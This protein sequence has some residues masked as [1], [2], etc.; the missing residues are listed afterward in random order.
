MLMRI[1]YSSLRLYS[2]IIQN[3]YNGTICTCTIR[4][5]SRNVV[6]KHTSTILHTVKTVKLYYS[7][8]QV[9]QDRRAKNCQIKGAQARKTNNKITAPE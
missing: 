1:Y 9:K 2:A 6:Y 5:E 4:V 3:L 7:S 8:K